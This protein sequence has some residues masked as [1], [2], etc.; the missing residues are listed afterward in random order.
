M[1][2]FEF[3]FGESVPMNL[4]L[5]GTGDPGWNARC[6]RMMREKRL[7]DEGKIEGPIEYDHW[8]DTSQEHY[9][10]ARPY[11]EDNAVEYVEVI[12]DDDCENDDDDDED[13]EDEDSW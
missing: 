1:G 9:D 3:L 6:Q 4:H 12:E 11:P 5:K 13:Y 7:R 10:T 2:L 8:M